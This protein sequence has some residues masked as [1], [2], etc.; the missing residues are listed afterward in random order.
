MKRVLAG[1]V[2]LAVLGSATGVQVLDGQ[3][4]TGASD[5]PQPRHDAGR[6]GYNPA[7]TG[8]ETDVGPA[9]IN[10]I[11][12]GG[13]GDV[14]PTVADGTV[15]VG[16]N[17]GELYAFDARDGERIWQTALGPHVRSAAAVGDERV[18]VVVEDEGPDES[19][20]VAVERETGEVDWRYAP[21][22]PET[23]A[24]WLE[25][26]PVVAGG[27]V[28]VGGNVGGPNVSSTGFVAALDPASGE[29]VWRR[30]LVDDFEHSVSTTPAVAD[31]TVYVFDHPYADESRNGT[32]YAI[33]GTDGDVTWRTPVP[34]DGWSVLATDGTVYVV[35]REAYAVDAATGDISRT[36]DIDSDLFTPP[37]L[38]NGT[39]Y[40]AAGVDY[41]AGQPD[42]T[43]LAAMNA[44]T[45]AEVWRTRVG[46]VGTPPAVSETL[47][48]VGTVDG[49]LYALD[50]TDGTVVWNYTVDERLGVDSAPAVV[51]D[52]VYLGPDPWHVYAFREGGTATKG[53]AVSAVGDWLRANPAVAF[54]VIGVAGGTLSGLVIGGLSFVP[55]GRL[56]STAP[57]RILA[58]KLFRTEADSVTGGQQAVAHLFAAA[59]VAVVY[60]TGWTLLSF[61]GP[62]SLLQLFGRSAGILF[63]LSPL[64]G[65]LA[66]LAVVGAAWWVLAYRW[67]P[68][69]EPVLD[70]PI[71]RV[72]RQWG[73]VHIVYGLVLLAVY[74]VVTFVLAI[75]VFQPF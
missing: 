26:Q 15:Y 6:T 3:V 32:L 75:A 54:L 12:S 51:G 43:A 18:F 36:Y 70:A 63:V 74:Q 62:M 14:S 8:P 61:L 38:A 57:Q 56:V 58:A 34:V 40:Y 47:V 22:H 35:G 24:A 19:G 23:P 67:L 33:D 20:V 29:T 46:W 28:Y 10:R 30:E 11:G 48:V 64:V 37:A 44:S 39:L 73:A 2:V 49:E 16:N 42:P 1:L 50:R 59:V 60:F 27:T 66:V 55:L 17:D 53:G 52:T 7:A 45:G 41:A 69:N 65:L 9:W 4:D 21:E 71:E 13:V 72:R 5:W 31:G 68:G 25:G